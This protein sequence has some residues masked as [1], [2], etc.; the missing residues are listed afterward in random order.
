MF[1]LT[2]DQITGYASLEVIDSDGINPGTVLD[3]TQ[4]FT[5][6]VDWNFRGPNTFNMGGTWQLTAYFES[7]G[8]QPEIAVAGPT[9]PAGQAT[10]DDVAIAVPANTI[11]QDGV[12]KLLVALTHRNSQNQ[13]SKNAGYV[14]LPEPL[15]FYS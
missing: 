8:P 13:L 14:E 5:I 3:R 7:V 6:E 10:Y 12:Y 15:Q 4:P 11:Q 1:Q 9:R 2:V